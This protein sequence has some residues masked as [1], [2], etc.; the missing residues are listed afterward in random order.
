MSQE[1]NGPRV[2][3]WY[4]I[5][6]EGSKNSEGGK[7]QGYVRLGS[8]NKVIVY[9]YG[10]GVSTDEYTACHAFYART[11]DFHPSETPGIT[12]RDEDN[13]FRDWTVI[14]VPYSTGDFHTG[15]A[16][17]PYTDLDG[18]KKILY[19]N[20]YVNYTGLMREAVKYIPEPDALLVTGFSAGGFA[21]ALLCDDVISNYF[22]NVKNITMLCDSGILRMEKWRYYAENVWHSKESIYHCISTDNGS[23]DCIVALNKK[24]GDKVKILFT[25]SVRDDTLSQY[26]MYYDGATYADK[27][28]AGDVFFEFLRDLVIDLIRD[29]PECG[30]FIWGDIPED[31]PRALTTHTV[32]C[33]KDFHRK[34][35]ACGVKVCDWLMDAVNGKVRKLGLDL[36]K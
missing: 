10:G 6:P 26:Q 18:T 9:F 28:D 8:E 13:P 25:C 33:F 22:P 35:Q 4:S 20:G 27:A 2:G 14:S 15:N 3:E 31:D 17:F 23:L 16:E 34:K 24:Y 12:S 5:S 32:I 30:V 19:H 1:N 7:W 29:V 11:S 21:A 36:L